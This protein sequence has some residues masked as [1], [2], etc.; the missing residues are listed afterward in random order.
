MEMLVSLDLL[1]QAKYAPT[2]HKT[3]GHKLLSQYILRKD[4]YHRALEKNLFDNESKPGELAVNLFHELL[5]ARAEYDNDDPIFDSHAAII[6][7]ARQFG[8]SPSA[9]SL[10]IVGNGFTTVLHPPRARLF[11]FDDVE[12]LIRLIIAGADPTVTASTGENLLNH[13][14]TKEMVPRS[15]GAELVKLVEMCRYAELSFLTPNSRTGKRV[16]WTKH[17]FYAVSSFA[18]LG[19]FTEEELAD[20]EA[21]RRSKAT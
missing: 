4:W 9:K 1:I 16:P 15:G 10:E 14:C 19:L 21:S 20:L 18:E 5:I 17:S 7:R 2:H 6:S 13:L 8:Y 12:F 3:F 11:I